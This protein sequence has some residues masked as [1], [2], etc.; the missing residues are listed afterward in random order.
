MLSYLPYGQGRG[1]AARPRGAEPAVDP[2]QAQRLLAAG[3]AA[4]ARGAL[5][6]GIEQLERASKLLP[7]SAL[8]HGELG[9]ALFRAGKLDPAEREL[10][11]ALALKAGRAARGAFLYSLGRVQEVRGNKHAAMEAY[12]KSLFLRPNKAARGRLDALG[13]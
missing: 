11:A 13:K 4:I 1:E 7:K 2:R 5:Q 9:W 12:K 3:R 10:R 8:I 6:S